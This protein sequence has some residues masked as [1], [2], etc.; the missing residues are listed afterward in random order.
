MAKPLHQN[1]PQDDHNEEVGDVE[2]E[3]CGSEVEEQ[4]EAFADAGGDGAEDCEEEQTACH[5]EGPE[6]DVG[7][8]LDDVEE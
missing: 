8:V 5:C 7:G 6:G 1:S 4:G 2:E 3:S